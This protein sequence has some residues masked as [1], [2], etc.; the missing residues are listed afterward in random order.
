MCNKHFEP[1]DHSCSRFSTGGHKYRFRR[2]ISQIVNDLDTF[3]FRGGRDRVA[4]GWTGG[5]DRRRIYNDIKTVES[6]TV[7]TIESFVTDI[8]ISR[9]FL[10][11]FNVTSKKRGGN[12]QIF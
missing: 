8:E 2:V 3:K 11:L 7:I 4:L 9:N 10:G 1:A 6:P 5:S 12:S